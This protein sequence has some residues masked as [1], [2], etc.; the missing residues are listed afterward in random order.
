MFK[1]AFLKIVLLWD[2]FWNFCTAGR[3]AECNTI[4]RM[5]F[6]CWIKWKHTHT[7]SDSVIFTVFSRQQR[8]HENVSM[9]PYV[10]IA[11]LVNTS[12]NYPYCF[13]F[14]QFFKCCTFTTFLLASAR[15]VYILLGLNVYPVHRREI[16][17]FPLRREKCWIYSVGKIQ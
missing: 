17:V 3:A 7:L 13:Y 5:R 1:K 6:A 11:C 12:L 8:L 2:K 16:G 4:R 9:L 15:P 10:Y 14:F